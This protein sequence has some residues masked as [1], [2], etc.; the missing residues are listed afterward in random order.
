MI[1][2]WIGRAAAERP[3]R[4]QR[5][6]GEAEHD[7]LPDDGTATLIVFV[8]PARVQ[9]CLSLLRAGGVSAVVGP[10]FRRDATPARASIARPV[11]RRSPPVESAERERYAFGNIRVDV[12]AYEVLRGSERV[13]LS[14]LEFD[15]LVAMAR[16]GGAVIP[17]PELQRLIPASAER[18]ESHSLRAHV[19][20]L[21]R[22]LEP[23]AGRPR[24]LIDIRRRGYRL[25]G[26]RRE[27]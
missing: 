5:E 12:A 15:L 27:S 10:F 7:R 22:K 17:A 2:E 1:G 25:A 23:D 14:A 18:G 3:L 9:R 26:A 13:A 16:A 6:A 20:N 21:R 4:H 11:P 19:A 8:D 24:Y